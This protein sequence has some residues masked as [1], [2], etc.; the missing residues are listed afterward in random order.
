MI[1]NTDED[2][3]RQPSLEDFKTSRLEDANSGE[4]KAAVGAATFILML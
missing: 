4:F 3:K 2:L 1:V